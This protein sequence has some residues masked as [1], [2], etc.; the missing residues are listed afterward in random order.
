MSGEGR[1]DLVR[2]LGQDAAQMIVEAEATFDQRWAEQLREM[3]WRLTIAATR[4]RRRA[5]LL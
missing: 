4:M 2:K 5:D 1:L 3:A